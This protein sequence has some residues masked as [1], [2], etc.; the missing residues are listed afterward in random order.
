MT[1]ST[2][3]ANIY[4][5]TVGRRRYDAEHDRPARAGASNWRPSSVASCGSRRYSPNA[6]AIR[7]PASSSRSATLRSRCRRTIR[8]S[9]TLLEQRFHR[10]LRADRGAGTFEFDITVVPDV[11]GLDPDADLDVA[12]RGRSLAA[13]ARR[14]SRRVGSARRGAA[15]FGRR[16]IPYAVDSV[17]RI[18]H[19][20]L[21]SRERGFLLHASSVVRNGRAF[22]FTGPSGAGKTTIA[23]LAPPDVVVLTDEIS[24]VRRHGGRYM[25]FGTPF[26]GEWARAASRSRPRWRR[27]SGSVVGRRRPRGEPLEQATTVRTLMRNILF[28]ADDPALAGTLLDT[29]CDFAGTRAGVPS[30][31][32]AGRAGLGARSYERR[33][34]SRKRRRL[35]ARKVAGEMVI[36]SADD[37][38]LYVLNG[39]APPSGRRPTAGRRSRRSSTT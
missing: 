21:L 29:A 31:F 12:R 24:Y 38:S 1:G 18:V 25:A 7:S 19:T 39:S 17:L 27:S 3:T 6:D 10:F 32:R 30:G 9:S 35:A 26:A 36:L 4:F 11:A 33:L 8:R 37:S 13:P 20:L 2:A 23:R 14:L 28:F 15:G 34:S 16:S 5:G 22:L